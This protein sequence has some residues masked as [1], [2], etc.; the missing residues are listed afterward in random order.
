[1]RSLAK[2]PDDIEAAMITLESMNTIDLLLIVFLQ[3]GEPEQGCAFRATRLDQL[4]QRKSLA[5]QDI[6]NL[7][8]R[9]N[10]QNF[11]WCDEKSTVLLFY[12]HEITLLDAELAPEVCGEA[13]PGLFPGRGQVWMLS[14]CHLRKSYFQE[15]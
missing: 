8:Q 7:I 1:M 2:P 3:A 10:R 15:V 5:S 12:S 4:F 14:R 11:L 13:L 9:L 6:A